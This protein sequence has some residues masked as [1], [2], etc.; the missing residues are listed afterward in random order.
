MSAKDKNYKAA[1]DRYLLAL[2]ETSIDEKTEQTDRGALQTLLQ[3]LADE[4]QKGLTF[5]MSPSALLQRG[6]RIS[7]SISADSFSAMSRTR[8][9]GKIS[10]RF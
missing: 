3:A 8:R 5:N 7:R 1:F 6:R 9:S 10:T 2:C 4:G